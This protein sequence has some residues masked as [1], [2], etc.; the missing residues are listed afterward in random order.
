MVKEGKICFAAAEQIKTVLKY[1]TDLKTSF[2][3][4]GKYEL[5]RRKTS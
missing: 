2:I 4:V 3:L 5:P 1:L